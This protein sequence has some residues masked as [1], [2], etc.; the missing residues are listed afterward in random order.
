M[1]ATPNRA[2]RFMFREK[3]TIVVV[4]RNSMCYSCL[5]VFRV[6]VLSTLKTVNCLIFSY[7]CSTP[8]VSYLLF[9]LGNLF[10]ALTSLS[11]FV[12]VDGVELLHCGEDGFGHE[13]FHVG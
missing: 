2:A 8:Y 6:A 11:V 5:A 7:L 4:A 1:R 12:V 9:N 10:C 13:L 3:R